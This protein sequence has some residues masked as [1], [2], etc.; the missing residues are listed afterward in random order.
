[1]AFPPVR[2]GTEGCRTAKKTTRTGECDVRSGD[3]GR[4]AGRYWAVSAAS[5]A[6]SSS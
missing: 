5:L 6:S 3:E 4:S 2:V 1:M